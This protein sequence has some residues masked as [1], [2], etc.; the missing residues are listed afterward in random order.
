MIRRLIHWLRLTLPPT[1][2]MWGGVV[3]LCWEG[4][5]FWGRYAELA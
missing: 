3:L 5:Y 2:A 4:I 1:W